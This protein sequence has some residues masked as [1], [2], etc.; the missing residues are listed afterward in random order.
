METQSWWCSVWKKIDAN[1][2]KPSAKKDIDL[3]YINLYFPSSIRDTIQWF[4]FI[5]IIEH[6]ANILKP[7]KGLIISLLKGFFMFPLRLFY[8]KHNEEGNFVG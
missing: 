6:T 1:V 4:P 5:A 8:D 7:N 2:Y 3:H